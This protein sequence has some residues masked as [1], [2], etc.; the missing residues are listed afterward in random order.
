MNVFIGHFFI[1]IVCK[2][3]NESKNGLVHVFLAYLPF[4]NK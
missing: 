1:G 3:F 2:M 4:D